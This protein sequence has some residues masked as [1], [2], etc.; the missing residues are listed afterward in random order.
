MA[1]GKILYRARI[2]GWWRGEMSCR[3]AFE[4]GIATLMSA[5]V[6]AASFSSANSA[7]AKEIAGIDNES[8]N[9]IS[10]YDRAKIRA[11]RRGLSVINP[12]LNSSSMRLLK[13]RPA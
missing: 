9:S 13:Y 12:R 7:I 2:R 4:D 10:A 6:F 8:D 3:P 1:G 11:S 5:D